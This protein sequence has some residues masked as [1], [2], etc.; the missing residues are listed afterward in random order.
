[1]RRHVATLLALLTLTLLTRAQ[2][3]LSSEPAADVR[4]T[5]LTYDL[6]AETAV[7][8]GDYTA[9]QI[10]RSL[11]DHIAVYIH[12]GCDNRRFIQYLLT[13]L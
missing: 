8:T 4:R 12:P 7:G 10:K 3:S 6:T 9:Y 5:Q 13:I 11:C 2:D 1:M